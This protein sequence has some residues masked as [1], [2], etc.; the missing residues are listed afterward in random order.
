MLR[1]LQNSWELA[2]ASA[3]V[4]GADKELLLFPVMSGIAMIVVTASFFVPTL[5]FGARVSSLAEG[6]IG[7]VGTAVLFLFYFSQYF[8]I[9]FFNSAL[10][11]A[12]MIRLDGGDPTLGD[13][14][15]VAWKHIGPILGYSLI[16]ATVGIVLRALRERAGFIGRIVVGLLGL[17]WNLATYLVVPVLVTQ[18]L[19]PIESIKKS[20]AIFKKTWGEQIAGNVGIGFVFGLATLGLIALSVPL[21]GL[22]VS[23]GEPVLIAATVGLLVAAFLAVAVLNS[24]LSG[25][26]Q[27]ALYRFAVTG[28]VAAGEAGAVFDR[29][30][31]ESAFAAP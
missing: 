12:A 20:A 31:L 4:L 10:I 6:S 9:I 19:G 23:A 30:A 13:G 24:A 11:G 3:R 1:K 28:E 29:R 16:A 22:A 2:K 25:I 21:V 14:L 17:A 26:Y 8:V 7:V 5:L 15:R 27:A 18:G